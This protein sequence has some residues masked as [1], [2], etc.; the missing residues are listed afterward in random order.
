MHGEK[1]WDRA[2]SLVDGC[3]PVSEACDNCWLAAMELRFNKCSGLLQVID[4]VRQPRFS[5]HI[6]C[7]E[8][9]LDIP[10]KTRKP[11]VWAIWSDLFH[12]KVPFKFIDAVFTV[13]K[14][15]PHH[16]FLALTK[17]TFR[18]QHY[19]FGDKTPDNIYIGTTVENQEQADRRIPHL[20][21]VP[22]NKFLSIEPCLSEIDLTP[23]LI[24]D[25][26]QE[27]N[28][29]GIYHERER[30]GIYVSG[31]DGCVFNRRSGED[32]ET[33]TIVGES[34][35]EQINRT[36]LA[37]L[38]KSGNVGITE[39]SASD[40][41]LR[42]EASCDLRTPCRL[43]VPKCAGNTGRHGDKPQGREPE[44]QPSWKFGIDHETGEHPACWT[45]VESFGEERTA[46]GE[47]HE[48][49]AEGRR[50]HCNSINVGQETNDTG[51][52]GKIFRR[53]SSYNQ[54]NLPKK[55]LEASSIN[56][57]ILGGESG[58]GARPMHPDWVRSVRDQCQAA[59]VP[60][61][62]KQ[63]GDWVT[64]DNMPFLT[65]RHPPKTAKF[66]G[67]FKRV[68]KKAAGRILDGRTHDELP[69]GQKI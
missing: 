28:E 8:D 29:R 60:F 63:W 22:G 26:L 65:F 61:F 54:R 41:H 43:D 64:L 23:Y 38:E 37:N 19:I 16:T 5:G 42:R 66:K 56:A 62:F 18:A 20:L 67:I 11:T 10:L 32:L 24:S 15:Q 13:M 17:R 36:F 21:Q 59:G 57:V 68:G 48:R 46:W 9:R 27:K 7:R 2:W 6:I 25:K 47:E 58:H 33:Q 50:C 39:P 44:E 69:W 31:C 12:E 49:E 4:G 53:V 34:E 55:N 14:L 35:W 1:Y 51:S 30:N 45:G 40:V 52:D 3:T